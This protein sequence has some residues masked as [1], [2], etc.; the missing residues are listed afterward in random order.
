MNTRQSWSFALARLAGAVAVA[1]TLG[2]VFGAIEWWLVGVLAAYLCL[3]LTAL[4]RVH[5]WLRRRAYE[6][7]PDLG[8]VWGDLVALIGRIYRRKQYHKRRTFELLREFRRLIAAMPDGVALLSRDLELRWF[9][10]KAARLLGL[11]RK[12][13]YGVRVD[14]FLRHPD[15][16]AYARRGGEGG[17]VVLRL[18][19]GDDRHLSLRLI[20]ADE[21]F[22][23]MVRDVTHEARI[24]A[25][26]KDFVANASHELR[27]PL[28]IVSGYLD[29]LVEDPSL[30]LAWREPVEE[31][32]RQALRMRAIVD[33]LLELSR[34][35]ASGEAAPMNPVDVG[36]VLALARKDALA[37]GPSR[38]VELALETDAWL[39]GAEGELHSVI[40]NLVSNAVKF[41]PPDGRIAL[42]YWLDGQ[43]G[44]HLSV[45]DTGVG[46][47]RV[48]L[49]RLTERFYR[50]DQGRARQHGGSGL[51]LAIVKHAL[52]RHGG[53]LTIDSVE[54]QG[55]TFTCHFPASR[56]VTGE[57]ARAS[58]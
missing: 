41:T 1:V 48:H 11:R 3:Q 19:D 38:R 22:V 55:S 40:S 24:E 35:E 34:M 37:A 16:V 14:N 43:G 10:R 23:L 53:S 45:A 52:Q 2:F 9:N 32:R 39:L 33:D 7:P 44:A 12:L 58:R 42:R 54:G 28:T 51:G 31:M 36:A 27:S 17:A 18:Q 46:I 15:F 20:R 25:M 21:Q 57:V 13:D 29:Q 5:G 26:R 30:D 56:I 4:Y 49:P 6:L 50:V 47:A 8:G